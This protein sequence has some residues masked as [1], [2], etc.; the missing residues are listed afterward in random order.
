MSKICLIAA[1]GRNYVLGLDG[2]LP[3]HLPAD[4]A[5][6]KQQTIGKPV[7]L[8]RKTFDSLG[9][10][11][12][13]KR[14]HFIISRTPQQNSENV[15]WV[16]SLQQAIDSA[17]KLTTGE[18]MVLGGGEIYSQS[19]QLADRLYLTEVD[20]SPPG[21]AFF[22][23]FDHAQWNMQIIAEHPATENQPGFVIKQYDRK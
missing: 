20:A 9:G 2:K 17:K 8:G 23:A 11:P 18:I 3:W 12:L 16:T 21:D 19:L 13:P 4:F 14:H 10:K 5:W 7:I 1:I 6:F 22:P 15:T